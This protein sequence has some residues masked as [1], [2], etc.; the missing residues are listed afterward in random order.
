MDGQ[1]ITA[2]LS[3]NLNLVVSIEAIH[4]SMTDKNALGIRR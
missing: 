3:D 2:R 1:I 4:G